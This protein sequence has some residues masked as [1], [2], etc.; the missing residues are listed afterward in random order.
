VLPRARSHV[1]A[2]L[3][4]VLALPAAQEIWLQEALLDKADS[5]QAQIPQ[6]THTWLQEVVAAASLEAAALKLQAPGPVTALFLVPSPRAI[7]A[8]VA[9]VPPVT[10]LVQ[11][12]AAVLGLQ[13][14]PSSQSISKG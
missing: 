5:S 9:L 10:A 8:A 13:A 11:A 7:T 6:H 1:L 2:N 4:L 12:Q 3:L 14:L